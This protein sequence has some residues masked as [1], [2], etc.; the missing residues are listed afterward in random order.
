MSWAA[1]RSVRFRGCARITRDVGRLSSTLAIAAALAASAP[2]HAEP[3]WTML[4]S[5]VLT[6]IGDQSPS[7]LRDIAVQIEQFRTVVGGLIHDANRPPSVPTVVFVVGERKSLQPIVPLYNGHPI[8][9]AGYMSQADDL[10]IMAL[11]VEG[12]EESAAVTFHEYTHLLV[13]NAVRSMPV[14][15]NEGL[16]EY[17]GSYT[18]VDRGRAATLGRPR[19]EH[20]LL[21][22]ERYLPIGELLTVDQSSPM[23]NEGARRSIFYAESWAATHYLMTTRPNGAAGINSYVN[24]AA[25]GRAPAEAFYNAFGATPEEFDK[26]MK[27]YLRGL[28]FMLQ[29]F[30]FPEKIAIV[31]P[32]P[33]RTMTP[34][35]VEA[36]LATAQLRVKRVD[37]ASPRIERA[38]SA[39]PPTAAGQ[40]GLGLLRLERQQMS[41]ALDAFRRAADLAPDDFTIQYVSGVSSLRADP[42]GSEEHRIQA[43]T[44][45]KRAVALNGAS[46]DAYAALAYVQMMSSATLADAR[47]SIE[48]AVVLAPGKLS[49]RL[50]YA[51]ILILQ[52]EL[53]QAR[54]LLTSIAAVKSDSMS[55]NAA[56]ARLETL[57]DYERRVARA[58]A[59]RSSATFGPA[60]ASPAATEARATEAGVTEAHPTDTP[61]PRE[62]PN[63]VRPDR[64][65]DRQTIFLLRKVQPGEERVLGALTKVD[66]AAQSVRFTVE[67]PDRKLVAAATS[68]ADIELTAFLDDKNFAV[69]C[70]A[71]APPDHVYLTWRPDSRWGNELVG[72][73]VALEF[74]PR[75][76]TP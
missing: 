22:R 6:V 76:Y 69:A 48:R 73:A 49:H 53:D 13:Q 12:Y 55:A 64:T 40:I 8:A 25:E 28:R 15:L 57:T 30:T 7:T 75:N 44:T 71:H 23:Y 36:W 16:A 46:A 63:A 54:R 26:E 72:T 65:R 70:G 60:P 10:N 9:L 5:G 38:A 67:L 61:R 41:E 2:V 45:L 14:W 32:S 58:A 29:R 33:G 19:A 37:E 62:F 59:E 35:E 18:L 20:I 21:L 1:S 66:C 52:G 27:V 50:R 34:A 31:E 51:D 43:L 3:K 47:V 56:S 42:Q 4:R 74:V 39:A 24:L 11:S 68:F 17:Y